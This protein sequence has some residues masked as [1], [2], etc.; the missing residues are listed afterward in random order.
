MSG[1]NCCFNQCTTSDYK[2]KGQNKEQQ[3]KLFRVTAAKS[4]FYAKWREK[5][6]NVIKKYRVLDAAFYQRLEK[7]NVYVCE[8]HYAPEDIELSSSKYFPFQTF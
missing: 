1:R 3:W 7:G 4:E 8:R 2:P 6:V 5:T